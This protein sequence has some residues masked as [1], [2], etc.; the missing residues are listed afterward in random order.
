[1]ADNI[2]FKT[3]ALNSLSNVTKKAGQLLFAYDNTS[4]SIYYDK[5]SSTRVKF[6]LDTNKL[7]TSAI[8]SPTE[9][10]SFLESNV[11]KVAGVTS[12][13]TTIGN[14]GILISSGYGSNGLGNQLWLND[15]ADGPRLMFRSK[16][17]TT[18][19]DNWS[20][21]YTSSSISTDKTWKGWTTDLS[22]TATYD[23]NTW[24]PVVGQAIP[25]TGIH[26]LKCAVQLNSG[27]VPSWC[28][29]VSGFTCNL[30][31]L[32][33][34]GGW[35]TTSAD[36]ILLNNTYK[37]VNDDKYPVTWY[38]MTNSSR[39]VFYCRGGG[40][41]MFYTDYPCVW[42]IFTSA[43]TESS[44]TVE[45]KTEQPI[46]YNYKMGKISANLNGTADYIYSTLTNPTSRTSYYIPFIGTS[47]TENGTKALGFNNG[48]AYR[49]LEGTTNTT[50]ESILILGNSKSNTT[51]GNK[52]G[53]IRLMGPGENSYTELNTSI[54]SGTNTVRFPAKSGYLLYKSGLSAIGSSSKPVYID[55][56]G[57]AIAIS[58]LALT[59]DISG[60]T[61]TITNTEAKPHLNFSRVGWNYITSPTG[62]TIAFVPT[63]VS[64]SNQTRL[65]INGT[66]VFPGANT[67]VVDLGTSDYK[68]NNVYANS[69][70]GNAATATKLKTA[71]TLTIGS[72][73]KS[74]DGSAGLSWSLSEIGA[75]ALTGGTLTG[76]LTAPSYITSKTIKIIPEGTA[77]G[78]YRCAT[79]TSDRGYSNNYILSIR[80]SYYSP[81]NEG[82]LFCITHEYDNVNITQ[83][84]GSTGGHI[85]SKIRVNIDN[86]G[87]IHIDYYM[88]SN[89]TASYTNTWCISGWGDGTVYTPYL[90][91]SYT[92]S[93]FEFETITGLKSNGNFSV[94]G[95]I[96]GKILGLGGTAPLDN[97]QINLQCNKAAMSFRANNPSYDT[98]IYYGTGGNE[99]LT[100]ATTN[101]VTHI[102]FANGHALSN[103][104][105]SYWNSIA[106][107]MDIAN[108]NVHIGGIAS[109]DYKFKVT[110]TSYFSDAMT[111]AGLFTYAGMQTGTA[112]AARCV[113]FSDS[114]V[115]GRPVYDTTFTYNP[116]TK[117]LGTIKRISH[118]AST[119]LYL[120][121]ANND[122]WVMT[123]DICSHNGNSNWAINAAGTAWFKVL[124]L[125]YTYGNGG[126]YILNANGNTMLAGTVYLDTAASTYISSTYYTGTSARSN[127]LI[128]NPFT[129]DNIDNVTD[130]GLH[131]GTIGS[132][133]GPGF[134]S[135]DGL[136]L[137]MSWNTG[138][139]YGAQLAFDD[140]TTANMYVRNKNTS[141]SSWEKVLLSNNY[142]DYT[143]KKDGTGASGTWG[144]SITGSSASCTGNAATATLATTVG[145]SDM[146]LYAHYSNEVNFG[147]TFNSN[148]IIYF[149]YRATDSKAIPTKFIFGGSTGTADLQVKNIYL[150]SGTSSYITASSYTGNAASATKLQTARTIFG[151]SFNGTSNVA[152]KALVYGSYNA[153]VNARYSTAALEIR[154]NGLVTTNQ[155]D[156]AYAPQIGFHWGG[157]VAGQLAL[158]SDAKFRFIKQDGSTAT[159]ISNVEGGTISSTSEI[160]MP[161]DEGKSIL[162]KSYLY[163]ESATSD[164]YS[165][166]T[167]ACRG[168]HVELWFGDESYGD[169][170][171][172]SSTSGGQLAR[173]GTQIYY[174]QGNIIYSSTEPSAPHIGAI[175]LKPV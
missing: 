128:N 82:Y 62:S 68:W 130:N 53:F 168:S 83:L 10:D 45:P 118:P 49:T 15:S 104:S 34:A 36:T 152:G 158:G 37:F 61:V 137:S 108:N 110:G 51:A 54:T 95:Y 122:N 131:F 136:I 64:N 86:D 133:A 154:E 31:V 172:V 58:S 39:P 164:S 124:N 148:S 115:V 17:S 11:V 79:L 78:W 112:D 99:A 109:I 60:N 12:A 147:G 16:S 87:K 174:H 143:V 91:S 107:A 141:W 74:F 113:W 77:E 101:T 146:K 25:I 33:I 90:V 65:A 167:V 59:G 149:G 97:Y 111:A 153:T 144:I 24:Y 40:K 52:S 162:A 117:E 47:G 8:T 160:S 55:G 73:G 161:G 145:T 170:F 173:N 142:T 76:A 120:G 169:W 171:S 7:L 175:W 166:F 135:S 19:W 116:V 13:A 71:V 48:F 70:S 38:Q 100:F 92:G 1:M 66:A 138:N 119:A 46:I 42:T 80:R 163:L 127:I 88:V 98:Y 35:G 9:A 102:Q 29:H 21:I 67:G 151:Q 150:G 3:G 2:I 72:T 50:G 81:E 75:L 84:S 5:D 96:K 139:S 134:S 155:S 22:D 114:T 132:Y 121:N 140:V 126:S 43:F 123:Q 6:N 30:E 69:F 106:P 93:A 94:D 18:T 20:E 27:S 156:I 32:T 89:G 4:G 41:Y 63:G 165:D 85:L 157:R 23:E 56:T 125:G 103:F 159:L 14:D 57:E 105:S 129:T 26:H 44:M 28:N